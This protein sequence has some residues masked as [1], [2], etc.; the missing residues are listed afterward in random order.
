MILEYMNIL[1]NP[2]DIEP[3]YA[4]FHVPNNIAR[5]FSVVRTPIYK[6]IIVKAPM[7]DVVNNTNLFKLFSL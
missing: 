5:S 3:R 4:F 2:Q 6:I 7:P 1:T